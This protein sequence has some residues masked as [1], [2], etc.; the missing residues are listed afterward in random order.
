MT[1]TLTISTLTKRFGE[2]AALTGVQPCPSRRANAW[3]SSATT[4]QKSTLMKIIW[5]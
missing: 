1:S 5:A 4:A 3:L 2:V